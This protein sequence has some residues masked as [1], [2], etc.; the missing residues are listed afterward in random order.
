MSANILVL[1]SG[2]THSSSLTKPFCFFLSLRRWARSAGV[3][4]MINSPLDTKKPQLRG[5]CDWLV[6]ARIFGFSQKL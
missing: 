4:A 5:Q 1:T 6:Y 2:A 3:N